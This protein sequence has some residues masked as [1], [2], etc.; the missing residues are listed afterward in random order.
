MNK[1]FIFF[2]F[3][4]LTFFTQIGFA[5]EKKEILNSVQKTYDMTKTFKAN[6]VQIS[7]LKIM[8]QTQTAKGEVFIKKPG[9][10]KWDYKA[11]DPQI[12][13]SNDNGIWLYMPEEKQV[14]KMQME[15]I[16]SS[17]T[18]AMFLIG[19]GKLSESFAVDK[20]LNEKNLITL[21]LLPKDSEMNIN[22]LLL[23]VNDKNY[24][25]T[26]SSVYDNLGNKTEIQFSSIQIN[27]SISD[28]FFNFDV[29]EGVDVVDFSAKQ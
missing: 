4:L 28:N 13:T 29:P 21:T 26:G 12:L 27:Q 24:Q 15:N 2:I 18:P 22:R 8:D 23:F 3:V 17:N 5:D 20:V 6:F 9:K 11:P 1:F 16:Y 10:M 25:I 19:K 14:T 7:Y